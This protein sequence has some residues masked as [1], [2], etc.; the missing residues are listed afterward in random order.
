[1]RTV[2]FP[3]ERMANHAEGR[4]A[5]GHVRDSPWSWRGNPAAQRNG[6]PEHRHAGTLGSNST[7]ASGAP[8]RGEH[9]SPS[10]I[11]TRRTDTTIPLS[12]LF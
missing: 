9:R 8:G 1:M 11:T 3:E 5:A 6:H 4:A 2:E 7:S 10:P 12:L